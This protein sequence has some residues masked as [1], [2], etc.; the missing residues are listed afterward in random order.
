[1]TDI[2]SSEL[3]RICQYIGN[4][5]PFYYSIAQDFCNDLYTTG[6]RPTELIEVTRWEQSIFDA[7]YWTMQPQKGNNQREILKASLSDGL[8]AAIIG[9]YRPYNRLTIRQLEYAM[10]QYITT[11]MIAKDDKE[12]VSYIFR[13]NK[14][15][16]L[17]AEGATNPEIQEYFGWLNPPMPWNYGSAQLKVQYFVIPTETYFVTDPAHNRIVDSNGDTIING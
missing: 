2:N 4:F 10:K 16:M 12:M 1:M 7:D 6:C 8:N 17:L 5:P 9:Q 11:G 3:L 14:V 15:K 13:Y